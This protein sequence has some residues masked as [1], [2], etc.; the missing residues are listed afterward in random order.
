M[1]DQG[2]VVT[3][4]DEVLTPDEAA[5]LLKTSEHGLRVAMAARLPHLKLGRQLIRCSRR[6]V[7]AWVYRGGDYSGTGTVADPLAEVADP[8]DGARPTA[9]SR[10]QRRPDGPAVPTAVKTYIPGSAR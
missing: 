3:G 1:G 4:Y 7:P 2:G 10:S 8:G 5:A 6:A 9:T